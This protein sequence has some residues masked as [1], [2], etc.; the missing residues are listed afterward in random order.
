MALKKT[1]EVVTWLKG[2]NHVDME[3][4]VEYLEDW[5]EEI[6]DECKIQAQGIQDIEEGIEQIKEQ[7]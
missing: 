2:H 3:R 7:L 4:R 1:R 5:A 6:I